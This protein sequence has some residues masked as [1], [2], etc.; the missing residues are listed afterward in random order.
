VAA[1]IEIGDT[2]G[3]GAVSIRRIAAHLNARA[4]TLYTHIDR[5]E[6]LF[7]LMVDEIVHEL[8]LPEEELFLDWREGLAGI[9]RRERQAI[10]EHPWLIEVLGQR[11]TPGPYRLRHIEQSMRAAQGLGLDGPETIRIVW[12]IKHYMLG[13][14]VRENLDSDLHRKDACGQSHAE[15]V[16]PYLLAMMADGDF[17]HLRPLIESAA[18]VKPTADERFEQGLAWLLD[19]IE[20]SVH[21]GRTTRDSSHTGPADS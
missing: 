5:K 6:D 21:R 1:A 14:V 19:G 15:A 4:M 20:A 3:I 7:D 13:C 10:L 9:A 8:L 18:L 12:A 16:R 2:E 17:P 11:L